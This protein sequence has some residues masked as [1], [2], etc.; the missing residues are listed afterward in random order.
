MIRRTPRS[1]RTDTLF[2]YTALFRS[3]AG[4]PGRADVVGDLERP[5]RPTERLAGGGHL[6]L[7][8][9]RAVR[10]LLA[11]LVRRTEADGGAAAH[12][13][14][15]A[16]RAPRLFDRSLARVGIVA[17]DLAYHVPATRP[18]AHLGATRDPKSAKP[19]EG[20]RE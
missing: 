5:V 8:Q 2:P 12:Q 18:A 15:L 7:A 11:G 9:R 17:V 20:E 6:V 16:L 4:A 13:H 3:I 14:R 1:T 10:G 19:L